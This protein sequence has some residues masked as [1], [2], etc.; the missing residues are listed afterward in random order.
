MYSMYTIYDHL[1]P[2][3]KSSWTLSALG[4]STGSQLDM[5]RP[6]AGANGPCAQRVRRALAIRDN[7]SRLTSVPCWIGWK[8][9]GNRYPAVKMYLFVCICI[10]L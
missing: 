6:V 1:T 3:S 9:D 2:S 8:I 7:A 5:D 10:H 4:R